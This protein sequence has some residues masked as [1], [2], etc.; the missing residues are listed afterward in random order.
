[1]TQN[2]LSVTALLLFASWQTVEPPIGSKAQSSQQARLAD[3]A[4]RWVKMEVPLR[5]S[6]DE[7]IGSASAEGFWQSTS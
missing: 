5:V 4:P 2:E 6:H 3:K 1:M 7:S